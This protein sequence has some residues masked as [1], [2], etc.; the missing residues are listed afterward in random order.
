MS[1]ETIASSVQVRGSEEEQATEPSAPRRSSRAIVTRTAG[2]Q[3]GPVKRLVSPSDLVLGY[4]SVHTS[5]EALH[6]GEGRIREIGA[7]LR[8]R[9]RIG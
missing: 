3:H 6:A 8:R 1:L 9:G 2:R 7:Q 4:Y 5:P